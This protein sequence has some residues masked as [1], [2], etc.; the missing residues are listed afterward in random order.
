MRGPEGPVRGGV[1]RCGRPPPRHRG[2]GRGKTSR[3]SILSKDC[4]PWTIVSVGPLTSAI[5]ATMNVSAL[6]SNVLRCTSGAFGQTVLPENFIRLP[7][8]KYVHRGA[9]YYRAGRNCVIFVMSMR[10][11]EKFALL[12]KE[13]MKGE[14]N[15]ARREEESGGKE[16]YKRVT[17]TGETGRKSVWRRSSCSSGC[18]ADIGVPVERR[19]SS[20]AR[21][22]AR[23][24][25]E[26]GTVPCAASRPD[27]RRPSRLIT[28]FHT[29]RRQLE[30]CDT[31]RRSRRHRGVAPSWRTPCHPRVHKN[32]RNRTRACRDSDAPTSRG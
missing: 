27:R 18:C 10:A 4:L 15:V 1:T 26:L 2:R 7:G 32:H 17:I 11:R 25:S 28:V 30:R 21:S 13:E 12:R 20:A 31:C 3:L 19:H 14:I 9:R 24:Q 16:S 22:I 23:E 5:R 8:S 29:P 6:S